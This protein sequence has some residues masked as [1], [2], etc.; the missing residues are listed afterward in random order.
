[1]YTHAKRS[2]ANVKDPSVHVRVRWIMGTLKHPACTVAWVARL[3]R[4][5]LSPG[6]LT[7]ISHGKN[8]NGTILLLKKMIIIA[9][10]YR[11]GE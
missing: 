2:H 4:T 8:P 1:M 10:E 7:R 3:C 5:W 6:E 11:P 9:K